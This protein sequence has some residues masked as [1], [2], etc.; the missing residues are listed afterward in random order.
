MSLKTTQRLLPILVASL[1]LL[2][3]C[4]PQT[5]TPTNTAAST[6]KPTTETST[7]AATAATDTPTD[8][9]TPTATETPSATPDQRLDPEE[10]QEW[11]I[12]PTVSANARAIYEEGLSRGT[13]PEHFS[14]VGDCQNITTYFLSIY[15]NPDLYELAPENEHLQDTIDHFAGNW[16]RDSAATAGGMN[17]AS[18]LSTRWAEDARCESGESPLACELRLNDPAIVLISME[19]SWGSENKVETYE[20]YM[21]MIIETVID[22][23]AVPILAT[24]ADNVEGGHQINAAI[25]RLAYEYDIP[26]WNFWR[27]VQPLPNH[28]LLDDG[29]H[30]TGAVHFNG[31]ENLKLGW[32]MRNLTALQTID[33]VW[34][35]L[36][37]LPLP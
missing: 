26:L 2:T 6:T 36:N 25:A 3:A 30:L 16:S 13:D 21:R 4:A 24:K 31:P 9:D 22:S 19:E 12:L 33:A 17:V 18:V 7:S 34:R 28:G 1:L 10:W 8:T 23:G 27:A 5:P 15:D 11:P 14:K 37:D 32:P 29:F 20:R 35:Q